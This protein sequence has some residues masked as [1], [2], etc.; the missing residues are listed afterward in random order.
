MPSND[1]Q[2]KAGRP[3]IVVILVDDMGYSDIGC[4]GGEIPTPHLDRLAGEGVRFSQFYNCARCCPTRASLLTGLYP[5][6][7]GV[8]AMVSDLGTPAYQGYL[9]DRCVTIAEALKGAGYRTC[10]SGKWHVGGPYLGNRPDTWHPGAPGSPTPRQRGFDAYYGTLG[11]GGSYYRP[12]TLLRDD[13]L[14]DVGPDEED[15]YYTDAIS[16]EAAAMINDAAQGDV[17]FFLYA[18]YTA[19]HWPLHAPEWAV[20]EFQGRYR[21]GWDAVRTARHE[22]LKGM[23]VL[24]AKWPISSRDPDAPPWADA[25]Q[26]DW[27]DRRMAVYAAQVHLM[28][29]GVGMILDALRQNGCEENTL[30]M[31]LS[32]NGGC[33]EFLAEDYDQ[34]NKHRYN[35]P[36][37][38]GRPVH[39][40]N[41]PTHA[42][43]P[44]QTFMS[45]GL[46]W[47]NAS[48]SPFR[49]FKRWTHEGGISTPFIVRWPGVAQADA[50]VHEPAHVVDIMATCLDAAGAE[51]PAEHAGRAIIPTEG[52]S[53]LPP[54][55]GEKWRRGQPIFFEHIGCRAVRDGR[56]KIVS[57]HGGGWELYDMIEDR[58]EVNDL[59][60]RNPDKLKGLVSQ[61]GEWAERCGALTPEEL[62]ARRG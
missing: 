10:H 60:E 23:G 36:T 3:N 1:A 5:H 30:V 27:E 24:D 57:P 9:N 37:R 52:Q 50:L 17:P 40:G 46:P 59:A 39:I 22:R 16:R 6:Q 47:A 61:Y 38:A 53:L 26:K 28:D 48:N 33:A 56:W 58:T 44:E 62:R 7:A 45:Y 15:Y 12:P 41:T 19:P 25:R 11:G 2:R 42:P 51:Y 21:D 13:T 49:K 4:Y 18:A 14:I 43:G 34:P 32:D 8:G 35:I 29:R 55:R 31:F 20:A 54:V